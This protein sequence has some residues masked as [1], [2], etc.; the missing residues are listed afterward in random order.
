MDDGVDIPQSFPRGLN[1]I[2]CGPG[3]GEIAAAPLNPRAG[4]L[5]TH[6]SRLQSCEA[7]RI[8]SLPMQHQACIRSGKPTRDR[9]ANPGPR[10]GDD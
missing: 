5:A 6:G 1:K 8:R 10:P 3:I 7:R 9:G 2:G 4:L